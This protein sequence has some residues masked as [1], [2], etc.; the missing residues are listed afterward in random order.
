MTQEH[1]WKNLEHGNTTRQMTRFLQQINGKE[2]TEEGLLQ[3]KRGFGDLSAERTSGMRIPI[4][5]EVTVKKAFMR[6]VG[7]LNTS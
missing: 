3:T 1:D 4:Y 6:Q 2:K 5:H 7:M